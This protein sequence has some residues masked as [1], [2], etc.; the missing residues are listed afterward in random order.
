MIIADSDGTERYRYEGYLP[1]EDLVAQLA[2]GSGRRTS[3][4]GSGLRPRSGFV[5]C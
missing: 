1:P 4:V 2:L 3:H 5:A